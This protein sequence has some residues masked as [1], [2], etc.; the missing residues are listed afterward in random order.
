MNQGDADT[1]ARGLLDAARALAERP[2][3]ELRGLW[4]RASALL[5]RQAL[6]VSLRT[7]WSFVAVGTQEASMRAQL[8]CLERYLSAATAR[9]AHLAWTALSRASHHHAYELA[10]SRDEL[11]GWCDVVDGVIRETERVWDR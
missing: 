3:H 1:V 8:L 4:P 2:G 11:L 7:Y 6:E 10:P 9:S 5:A